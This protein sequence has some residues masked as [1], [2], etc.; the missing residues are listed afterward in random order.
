MFKKDF[1]LEFAR[2]DEVFD[3]VVVFLEDILV[4]RLIVKKITFLP[5]TIVIGDSEEI[6]SRSTAI[7]E[8]VNTCYAPKAA[9]AAVI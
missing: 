6:I 1:L 9:E 8:Y 5:R 4:E 3:G 7:Y 2:I